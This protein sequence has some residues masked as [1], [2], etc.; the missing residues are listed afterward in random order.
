MLSNSGYNLT[1]GQN[2]QSVDVPDHPHYNPPGSSHSAMARAGAAV[3][4]DGF[5]GRPIR[6]DEKQ[7]GKRVG[8]SNDILPTTTP[9]QQP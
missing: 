8:N 6:M 1:N 3:F 5:A 2:R 4:G 7:F 9:Y